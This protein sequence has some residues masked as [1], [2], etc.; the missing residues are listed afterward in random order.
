MLNTIKLSDNHFIRWLQITI[1]YTFIVS[2]FCLFIISVGV[3][4]EVLLGDPIECSGNN[5]DEEYYKIPKK[6]V[7]KTLEIIG[8][9]AE[10]AVEQVIP[11][12][13]AGAAAG[14]IGATALKL[15]QTLPPAQRLAVVGATAFV[16]AVGTQAG[17]SAA[18]ALMKNVDIS[19]AIKNSPHSNPDINRVPSPSQD[20]YPLS[21]LEKGE[22]G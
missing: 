5:D 10:K 9:V 19:S 8:N 17:L 21:P 13:G 15:T 1:F 16:G 22:I 2:L 6:T 18:T 3:G 20:V 11:N 7:D 12:I 14:T 4:Y